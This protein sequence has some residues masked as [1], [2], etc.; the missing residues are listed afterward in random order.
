MN[1][2][3]SVICRSIIQKVRCLEQ[4]LSKQ[5][6]RVLKEYQYSDA[7]FQQAAKTDLLVCC[8]VQTEHMKLNFPIQT[9]FIYSL[10]SN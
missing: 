10:N 4:A 9:T 5:W 8:I 7:L 3:E 2:V 6:A 1:K